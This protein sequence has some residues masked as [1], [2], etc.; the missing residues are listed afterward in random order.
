MSSSLDYT[1]AFEDELDSCATKETMLVKLNELIAE[2]WDGV[3]EPTPLQYRGG[4]I[5]GGRGDWLDVMD[6]QR[7]RRKLCYIHTTHDASS[8]GGH[9]RNE[10]LAQ[11]AHEGLHVEVYERPPEAHALHR[12]WDNLY[13]ETD[14]MVCV[15]PAVSVRAQLCVEL[16]VQTDA[17]KKQLRNYKKP[18]PWLDMDMWTVRVGLLLGYTMADTMFFL[19]RLKCEGGCSP[20]TASECKHLEAPLE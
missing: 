10:L 7:G 3:S 17:F 2:H 16:S 11:L 19:H 20:T 8:T 18:E 4:R 5:R 9:D 13:T 6:V 14:L 15:S 12:N 1:K